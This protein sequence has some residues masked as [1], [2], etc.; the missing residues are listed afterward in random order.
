ML[1]IYYIYKIKFHKNTLFPNLCQNP[2]NEIW[3]PLKNMS[4][5]FFKNYL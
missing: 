4:F 5:E 1:Q 2:F 3:F